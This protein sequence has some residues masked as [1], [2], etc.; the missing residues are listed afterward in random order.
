MFGDLPPVAEVYETNNSVTVI[1][2]SDSLDIL[3]R[4]FSSSLSKLEIHRKFDALMCQHNGRIIGRF[5][6]CPMG[7]D[8]LLFGNNECSKSLRDV[9]VKGTG[10][11]EDVKISNGDNAISLVRVI[12]QD[13]AKIISKIVEIPGNFSNEKWFEDG[14]RLFS[15]KKI[16]GL[17]FFEIALPKN[18]SQDFFVELV[19]L[20]C[21]IIDNERWSFLRMKSGI[22]GHSDISGM[23][24][25]DVGLGRLVSLDKGCY[26]GQ[27][28][29]ARIES[30][31]EIKKKI[32]RISGSEAISLGK[33][34]IVDSGVALVTSVCS[35]SKS[36]MA[37][38]IVPNEL[39]INEEIE[40]KGV[41]SYTISD[42]ASL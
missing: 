28:I 40:I 27:E 38:A 3:N 6:I 36:V 29:H 9:L 21:K 5:S 25:M 10:W 7:N 33:Q 17:Y 1:S 34:R 15:F 37:Y 30:R 18:H 23:L 35:F 42:I 11:D 22:L 19:G 14:N 12:G 16:S 8:V 2:G 26:P 31:G 39:S 41:G 24:P 4:S 20:G 32:V 13:A